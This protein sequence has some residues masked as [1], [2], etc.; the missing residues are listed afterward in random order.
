MKLH[1]IPAEAELRLE[2][3][4]KA[5]ARTTITL[6]S[7]SCELFGSELAQNCPYVI[8][9]GS[10]L[11]LFTWHGCTLAVGEEAQ[12]EQMDVDQEREDAVEHQYVSTE[13]NANIAHVNTHAQLEALRD[14]AVLDAATAIRNKEVSTASKN[15]CREGPRVLLA[16]PVDCG[17]SA[18]QRVLISY[19]V[20]LGRSPML[21]DLDVSQNSLSVPGTMAASSI[22]SYESVSVK[23]YA[24]CNVGPILPS[25]SPLVFW[26]GSTNST[27]NMALTKLQLSKLGE[28]INARMKYDVETR[29]AG[30]I[31]NTAGAWVKDSDGYELLKHAIEALQIDVILVIGQDRLYSMLSAYCNASTSNTIGTDRRRERKVIKLPVSGGVVSRDKTIRQTAQNSSIKSYFY[32]LSNFHVKSNDIADVRPASRNELSPY[33]HECSFNDIRIFKLSAIALATSMLPVSQRQATDPIQLNTVEMSSLIRHSILA[34]CHPL[35]VEAYDQTNDNSKLYLSA[36]SGFVVVEEID[37]ERNLVKFLSP[38]AGGLPSNTMLMGN[39][40]W[41]N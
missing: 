24:A 17:K 23:S 1:T 34:V 29:N 12:Q 20:K 26:S 16:G 28:C 9:S 13:T 25:T 30:C 4:S 3:S 33:Q 41:I 19:A 37:M 31:V 14:Q 18:L 8:E 6:K 27:E 7:G 10:K 22:S 32:G 36:V 40:T 39:I 35:S 38:C 11:A 21:V 15:S 2:C 5:N